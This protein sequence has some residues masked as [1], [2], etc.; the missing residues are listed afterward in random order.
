MCVDVRRLSDPE[1]QLLSW[2]APLHPNWFELAFISLRSSKEPSQS[3]SV[4][5]GWFV[6]GL[7]WAI[8]Q[9]PPSL[10]WILNAVEKLTSSSAHAEPGRAS[11]WH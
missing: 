8:Q 6:A 2:W 1:G 10:F 9:N 5:S 11:R 4:W 7:R 3:S